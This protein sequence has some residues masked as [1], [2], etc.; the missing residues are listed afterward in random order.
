LHDNLLTRLPGNRVYMLDEIETFEQKAIW[1]LSVP[2]LI[3]KTSGFV[4]GTAV[5]P[6]R[7]VARA[8]SARRAWLEREERRHGKRVDRSLEVLRRLLLAFG[9]LLEGR[10]ASLWSDMKS[11]YSRLC[12]QLFRG[13]L[14]HCRWSGRAPR[15]ARNPLFMINLT[16]AMLR[17]NNGRLR[18][19]SWLVSKKA[20]CLELQLALF[21]GYRNYVRKRRNKD[22]EGLTPAMKLGVLPRMLGID[23]LLGWRQDWG[24]RSIH[25]LSG[26]GSRAVAA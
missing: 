19:R 18:R 16:D 21:V 12:R 8:G 3:D 6:I 10:P 17:D 7:R 15:D 26:D 25:P 20:A 24:P 23:E 22:P 1:P 11:A 9:A 5:A 2:V 4:V 14:T 13:Q